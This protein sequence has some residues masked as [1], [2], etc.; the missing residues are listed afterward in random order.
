MLRLRK[1]VDADHVFVAGHSEGGLHAIRVAQAEGGHVAGLLLLS[2]PGS[3]MKDLLVKQIAG[4]LRD[5]A[6][7]PPEQVKSE[8]AMLSHTLDE[9]VEAHP[10][11]PTQASTIPQ[12]QQ[13]VAGLIAP[14]TAPLLRAL[15]AFDP[16]ST[17]AKINQPTFI[18]NGLKDV[19]VDPQADAGR[20]EQVRRDAGRDVTLFLAPD[21]NHILEHET[22]PLAKLRGDLVATQAHYNAADRVI[23][24]STVAAIVGWL[25]RQTAPVAKAKGRGTP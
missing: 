4:N 18:F 11:D 5:G 16:A 25:A 13:L 24:K 20:L 6:K 22:L 7:L 12:L 10:V 23:D 2:T 19:Q 3:S 21:A 1:D 9:F 17:L 8:L 15:M 14:Q